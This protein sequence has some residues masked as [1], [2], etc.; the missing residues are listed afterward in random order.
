MSNGRLDT[1]TRALL[2]MLGTYTFLIGG[3]SIGTLNPLIGRT[4][5]ILIAVLV[6]GWLLVRWRQRWTWHKTPLDAAFVLWWIT[7]GVSLLANNESWRRITIGMWYIALYTG[8]WFILHD[9]I[10]NRRLK[11]RIVVESLLL[12]GLVPM[13]F[14]YTQLLNWSSNWFTPGSIG[15]APILDLPRIAGTLD[16][17]NVMSSLLLV[18]ILLAVGYIELVRN[19]LARYV[20][21]VYILLAA[22]LLFVTFGRG[23]WIG[24][25]IGLTVLLA[26]RL[27]DRGLSSV[28]RLR[29]QWAIQT[30]HRKLTLSALAI[31]ILIVGVTITILFVRSFSLGGRQLDLRTYI[32]DAAIRMFTEKPI[33]G[34]GLFS[35]GKGLLR[36]TSTPP[37][38]IHNQAHSAPL[39]IAAE[40]G[41]FGLLA[42]VATIGVS[43]HAM[44]KNWFTTS[45][46][47]RQLLIG[48]IG[49]VTGLA[50][51]HL[52]DIPSIVPA[53]FLA[54]LAV[55]AVTVAPE[56]ASAVSHRNASVRLILLVGLW[57]L[58]LGAGFWSNSVYSGY[59]A[60]M[61]YGYA[62]RDYEGAARRIQAATDG[63]PR[64]AIYHLTQ[65]YFLAK[66][67]HA[68]RV[69]LLPASLAAYQ[70]FTALEPHYALAWANMS[71]LYWQSGQQQEAIQVMEQALALAPQS[72]EIAANLGA[73][74]EAIGDR[75]G[76]RQAYTIAIQNNADAASLP[77]WQATP[78]RLEFVNISVIERIPYRAAVLINSGAFRQ[79]QETWAASSPAERQD[80]TGHLIALALAVQSR[81][82]PNARIALDAIQALELD[83]KAS[84]SL[85]LGNAY[86][87]YL[88]GDNKTVRQELRVVDELLASASLWRI[89]DALAGIGRIQYFC[90]GPSE[91]LLPQ[92][93][94]LPSELVVA[95]LS[96]YLKRVTHDAGI[97]L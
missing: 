9:A 76:A 43:I 30:R 45:G 18:L 48:P 14:G 83:S 97:T 16:N 19:R 31:V 39:N 91:Y 75:N 37:H 27:A 74:R 42:L 24:T 2:T 66:A 64:L 68:G 7:I 21:A 82:A 13:F 87:A 33:T 94:L 41:L 23:S 51:N 59:I 35:F 79:A 25:G 69:D 15:S 62:T 77:E 8:L 49:A 56:K 54:G 57:A 6:I 95:N 26:L 34:H 86:F 5:L 44:R 70:R 58:I 1:V 71:A 50:I 85:H 47:E 22:F 63:D 36:L 40:M 72:W 17:P 89:N 4:S 12:S 28:A 11:R 29:Q 52:T 96:A 55:L 10:A 90:I 32:Y 80:S 73:Y 93:P 78:L 61:E 81:D 20:L 46:K 67:A 88:N 60:S 92:L 84:V 53:I 3:T 38:Q 65:G